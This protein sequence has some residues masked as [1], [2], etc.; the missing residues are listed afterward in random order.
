MLAEVQARLDSSA[1][2]ITALEVKAN[3]GGSWRLRASIPWITIEGPAANT[4]GGVPRPSTNAESGLGDIYASATYRFG[5]TLGLG[6]GETDYYGQFD[7]YRTIGPTTPFA[8]V[9]YRFLGSSPVY[10][11]EDGL[12]ASA[13]SHFRVSAATVWTVAV[14]WSEP[15]VADGRDSTD[16]MLS[17]THDLSNRWQINAYVLKGFTSASPDHG[18]GLQLTCRF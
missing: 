2:V 8:S 6:T 11:L 5:E 9:G 12:L 14:N 3:Q 7:F 13:G 10:R 17:L 4:G 1:Q 15:Y 16:A 18:A